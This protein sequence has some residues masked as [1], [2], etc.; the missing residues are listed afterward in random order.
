MSRE[1]EIMQSLCERF[2]FLTDRIYIQREK[3]IFT[4]ALEKSEFMQVVRYIHDELDF[5]R[6]HHV[7]GTDDKETLGLIYLFS[8]SDNIILALRESVP[9]TDPTVKSISDIYPSVVLHERELVDLFGVIV[10]GLP[11]GPSYPLTDG[12]PKGNYPMINDL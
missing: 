1:E 3:R 8:G 11:D 4:K 10:E 7:I 6:A 2:S 12:W 5:F 9:K